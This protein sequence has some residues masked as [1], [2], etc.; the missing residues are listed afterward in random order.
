MCSRA[1]APTAPG[2][3]PCRVAETGW[4]VRRMRSSTCRRATRAGAAGCLV[5]GATR[6][7]AGRAVQ[8]RCLPRPTRRCGAAGRPMRCVTA[9]RGISAARHPAHRRA[10]VG[11]PGRSARLAIAEIATQI[12]T[13]SQD[14]PEQLSEPRSAGWR[15]NLQLDKTAVSPGADPAGLSIPPRGNDHCTHRVPAKDRPAAAKSQFKRDFPVGRSMLN[16]RGQR[17]R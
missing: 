4:L 3:P 7:P 5:R 11:E 1:P 16:P 12:W 9:D 2:W 14:R 17:D 6:Y 15:P 8:R 13:P 10:A